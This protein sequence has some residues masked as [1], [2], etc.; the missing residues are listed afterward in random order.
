MSSF[1]RAL[2]LPAL[3]V[4]SAP[5]HAKDLRNRVGVG[6]NTWSGGGA[7]TNLSVRWGLPTSDPAVNVQFEGDLG[8]N[9]TAGSSAVFGGGRLLYGVVAEDNMNLYLAGGA[10]YLNTEDGSSVRIQPGLTVDF[11][12]F[13]LENLGFTGGFGANIDLGANGAVTTTG[14]AMGGFHYWF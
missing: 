11:F 9:T 12:L 6:F 7:L 4:A 2:A 13:G 3:L 10:G 5:A 8:L 14:A 1:L